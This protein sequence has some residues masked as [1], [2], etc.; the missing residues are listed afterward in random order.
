MSV[1]DLLLG[2]EPP[3]TEVAKMG[4]QI[5]PELIV[6]L[7]GDPEFWIRQRAAVV[8]GL[9]DGPDVRQPLIQALQTDENPV[10]RLSAAYALGNV[11]GE[12][13][14]LALIG[15]LQDPDFGVRLA[16]LRTLGELGAVQACPAILRVAATDPVPEVRQ[17]ARQV[18][19]QLG[20]EIPI[21]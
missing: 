12:L 16:A 13:A 15:A 4:Q 18:A 3:L 5:V 8:L 19:A 9:I 10:V 7:R 14:I 6:L 2:V 17:V 1:R 11:G 20:C 21:G